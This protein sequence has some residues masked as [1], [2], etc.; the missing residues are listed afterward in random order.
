MSFFIISTINFDIVKM[1]KE[2][3]LNN[4]KLMME[5]VGGEKSFANND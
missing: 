3:K 5:R 1:D 4:I 2:K